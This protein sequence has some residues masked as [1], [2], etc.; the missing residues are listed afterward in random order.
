MDRVVRIVLMTTVFALA[1]SVFVSLTQVTY[2]SQN[3][4]TYSIQEEK[5]SYVEYL[6]NKIKKKKPDIRHHGIIQIINRKGSCTA[7]VINDTTA[8]TA[9]HCMDIT[10]MFIRNEAPKIH[11]RS[12]EKEKRLR[13]RIAYLKSTCNNNMSCLKK[14]YE[15]Q[16]ELTNE[17]EARRKGFMLKPESFKVINVRGIDTKIK[18]IAYS[19]DGERDYGFIKGDFK[20]FKKMP[21][22]PNWSV[23]QGDILRACGFFGSRLPPTCTDFKAIGNHHFAYAG[24]SVFQ[25]GVSGGPVIDHR[26]YVVGIAI[27][28]AQDYALIEPMIGM[29]NLLSEEERKAIDESNK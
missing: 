27:A 26:G 7:F 10:K 13:R 23:K 17:L 24:E 28:V 11:K 6:Y 12:L 18:G 22:S 4:S 16:D 15:A 19:K 1:Y 2:N 14:I 29:I 21:I 3:V 20:N 8:M 25:K 5:P 9:A